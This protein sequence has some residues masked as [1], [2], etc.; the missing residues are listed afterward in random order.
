MFLK[1]AQVFK[2]EHQEFC[3]VRAQVAMLLV[4]FFNPVFIATDYFVAPSHQLKFFIFARMANV[5]LAFFFFIFLKY[6]KQNSLPFANA[7][8]IL[9]GSTLCIQL[10]L[11][12]FKTG[13]FNS[14]YYFGPLYVIMGFGIVMPWSPLYQLLHGLVAQGIYL[15]QYFFNPP[16]NSFD[17]FFI[18]NYFMFAVTLVTTV[19]VY[20]QYQLY[21]RLKEEELELKKKNAQLRGAQAE[22][23]RINTLAALGEFAGG[24]AHN[25][26]TY[27]SASDMGLTLILEN[28]HGDEKMR[29]VAKTTLASIRNT[30]EI[31]SSLEVFS[32]RDKASFQEVKLDQALEGILEILKLSPR[33]SEIKIH[34]DFGF[35]NLLSCNL[36]QLNAA[37]LNL[38]KNAAQAGAKNIWIRTWQ[39]DHSAII[40]VKDDGYG[41]SDSVQSKIFE[42][43]FTTKDVGEGT[44]LGLWMVHRTMEEH[45]G[46]IH[47]KS[48]EGKGS[49]FILR[50]PL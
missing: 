46:S 2:K 28:I 38:F 31:V 49:E 50:I 15:S 17:T 14:P 43:F 12:C 30:K 1:P 7:L 19:A 34:Q 25:I 47:V 45:G 18:H 9:I 26:N 37:F 44:G 48:E 3:W 29:H 32:K 10:T 24:I 36:Q 27:L 39:E 22:L 13:G 42:P 40:S 6:F 20:I 35:T 4:I 33:V 5:V 23:V 16:H 8:A 41:M 21:W 11:M